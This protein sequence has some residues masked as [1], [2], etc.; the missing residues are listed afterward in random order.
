MMGSSKSVVPDPYPVLKSDWK[1]SNNT[2]DPGFSEAVAQPPSQQSSLKREGWKLGESY[3]V[4]F[5]EVNKWLLK[6]WRDNLLCWKRI[7]RTQPHVTSWEAFKRISYNKA[8][9]QPG[10]LWR[11]CIKAVW[12]LE[13]KSFLNTWIQIH[14]FLIHPVKRSVAFALNN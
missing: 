1:G 6:N 8:R 14:A 11:F 13:S 2:I 10:H 9:L 5:L 3:P 12:G 4:W 7:A